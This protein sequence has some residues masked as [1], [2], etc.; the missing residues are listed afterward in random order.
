[1]SPIVERF[2]AL[3]LLLAAVAATGL[4]MRLKGKPHNA[5]LSALHKLISLGVGIWLIVLTVRQA[6]LS[7]AQWA[8]VVGVGLLYAGDAATGALLSGEKEMP[9]I[10]S[11]LHKILPALTLVMSGLLV[12]VLS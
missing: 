8:V 1:M 2:V 10:L 3:G 11:L 7:G 6:P 5:A 9:R 4:R 12:F